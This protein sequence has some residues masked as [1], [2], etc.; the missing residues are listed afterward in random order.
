MAVALLHQLAGLAE[1]HRISAILPVAHGA[2]MVLIDG[3]GKVLLA[4][5]YEDTYFDQLTDEYIALR[6]PFE[7]S[8]SPLLPVGLNLGKQIL[9]WNA[10]LRRFSGRF[11]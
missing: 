1:R 11:A 5:D 3:T 10:W 8:F 7:V 4:P 9:F 6:D 2:A